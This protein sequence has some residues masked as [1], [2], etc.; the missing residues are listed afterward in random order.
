[1]QRARA[2][3]VAFQ[4]SALAAVAQLGHVLVLGLVLGDGQQDPVR[5][6]RRTVQ[7]SVSVPRHMPAP[8]ATAKAWDLMPK[9][10]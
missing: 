8:P 7:D 9:A 5:L 1:V 4:G 6:R 2:H 3:P 10:Q